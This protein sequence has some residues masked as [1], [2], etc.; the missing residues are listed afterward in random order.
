MKMDE[1]FIPSFEFEFICMTYH[2]FINIYMYILYCTTLILLLLCVGLGRCAGACIDWRY[3]YWCAVFHIFYT[4]QIDIVMNECTLSI[5]WNVIWLRLSGMR[6]MHACGVDFHH[7]VNGN[8]NN[9]G[10]LYHFF[11]C[12]V[13][14]AGISIHCWRALKYKI[15]FNM[16]F[17][18]ASRTRCL[19]LKSKER[20]KGLA[21]YSVQCMHLKFYSI[22]MRSLDFSQFAKINPNSGI[23]NSKLWFRALR[24]CLFPQ[25]GSILIDQ[26]RKA[27][28]T[29]F[30]E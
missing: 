19:A 20:G 15:R 24:R 3:W 11:A 16:Q 28:S 4:I 12:C 7:G 10:L 14:V 9:R 13:A 25:P 21:F 23:K 5:W 18:H 6:C 29:L 22:E 27:T 17:C 1:L 2:N 26:H 8:E 30:H